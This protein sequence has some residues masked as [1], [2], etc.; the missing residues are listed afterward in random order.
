[1]AHQLKLYQLD[2]F[3]RRPFRGNPA[4]VVPLESWLDVRLLHRVAAEN[5]LPE[6]AF[7]APADDADADADY[8]LRWF[9]PTT[10]IGLCGHATLASAFV[11]RNAL[12]FDGETIRFTTERAGPLSVSFEGEACT[13]DFPAT[14]REPAELGTDLV[15]A[16]GRQ[17]AELYRA[18]P[19]LMAVFESKKDVHAIEPDF[20]AIA[21]LEAQGIVCT[22]PGAG[23]DF[24][25]RYFAPRV[26]V[27]EDH[28]TG[29]AHCALAP[30]WA[31]RL[32]KRDLDAHQVSP[33]GA[34]M[35]CRVRDDRVLLTGHCV[36]YLEGTIAVPDEAA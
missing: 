17:P 30:F 20:R 9:T 6:T 29:S 33:R 26:G 1:M 11:L 10:E 35:R 2:A 28:A 15:R 5:N 25:S 7:F 3:T 24:V 18:G 19:N 16:L 4:A 21:E 22:A 23:H 27:P 34:E 8:H 14:P 36:T 32:N 13:M 12:G 31:E